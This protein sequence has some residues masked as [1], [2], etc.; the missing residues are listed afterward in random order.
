MS[1][2]NPRV[3]W[4]FRGQ[5]FSSFHLRSRIP[6][7]SILFSTAAYPIIFYTVLMSESRTDNYFLFCTKFYL[8]IPKISS[9][10][11]IHILF[12]KALAMLLD[13]VS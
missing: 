9:A 8:I 10:F 7:Q 12:L 13:L 6:E 4:L 1:A 3:V 2:T 5:Y 11:R